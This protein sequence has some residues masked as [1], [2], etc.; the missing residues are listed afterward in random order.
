MAC[1][2]RSE[3][4]R[5]RSEASAAQPRMSV[6]RS[7]IGLQPASGLGQRRSDLGVGGRVAG[8]GRRT[9]QPLHGR[10][11][12]NGSRARARVD[13]LRDA[14]LDASSGVR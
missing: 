10:S 8:R 9:D 1:S 6:A 13:A 7:A 14:L 11:R 5:T 4:S 2:A 3:A 12:S